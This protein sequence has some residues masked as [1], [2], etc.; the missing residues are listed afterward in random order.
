MGDV[1]GCNDELQTLLG[2]KLDSSAV[3][4]ARQALILEAA[5]IDDVRS[6][7]E[8]RRLVAANLLEDMLKTFAVQGTQA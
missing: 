6:P 4:K 8:Y 1:Q 5:P 3:A 2:G 7:A